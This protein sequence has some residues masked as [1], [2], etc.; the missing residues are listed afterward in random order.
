MRL[1]EEIG[2]HVSELGQSLGRAQ[3]AP[4]TREGPASG[5]ADTGPAQGNW[6]H[7]GF[8]AW[9]PD[10]VLPDLSAGN[11]DWED[12]AFDLDDAGAL[13]LEPLENQEELDK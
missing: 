9:N 13:G 7:R 10:Y 12:V 1:R 3:E 11:L 5:V 8:S 2:G 4:S 6:G